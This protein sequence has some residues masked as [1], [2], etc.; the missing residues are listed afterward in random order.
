MGLR[1][2][3][4]SLMPAEGW[5]VPSN[6]PVHRRAVAAALKLLYGNA[7]AM[8]AGAHDGTDINSV[9]A[10][11]A[12][13]GGGRVYIDKGTVVTDVTIVPASS[14][15][16]EVN[17]EATIRWNG[18]AGG[19]VVETPATST[20]V[21]SGFYGR[22]VIDLNFL[23]ET[24]LN[25]HS[26]FRGHWGGFRYTNGSTTCALTRITGDSAAGAAEF[27]NLANVAFNLFDQM[28]CESSCG[29]GYVFDGRNDPVL[30]GYITENTFGPI[31]LANCKLKGLRFVKW[32]DNNV[33]WGQIRVSINADDAIGMVFQDDADPALDVGVYA[34]VFQYAAIDSFN[35]PTLQSCRKDDG[36]AFTNYTTAAKDDTR[37]DVLPLRAAPA[38]GDAIYVGCSSKFRC[39]GVLTSIAGV[40]GWTVTWEYWNGAAYVP[41]PGLTDETVGFTVFGIK[42]VYWAAAPADWQPDVING[43]GPY[44]HVRGR[45][46]AYPGPMTTQPKVTWIRPSNYKNRRAIVFNKSY[47]QTFQAFFQDPEAEGGVLVNNYR[48]ENSYYVVRMGS[49][50]SPTRPR[51][52][53]VYGAHALHEPDFDMAGAGGEGPSVYFGDERH[54]AGLGGTGINH[55]PYYRFDSGDYLWYD[56]TYNGFN[57]AVANLSVFGIGTGYVSAAGGVLRNA[58]RLLAK[59]TVAGVAPGAVHGNYGAKTDISTAAS[60]Y[61]LMAPLYVS[62]TA[63]GVFGAETLTVRLTVTYDDSSTTV[64]TKDFVAAGVETA[65]SDLELFNLLSDGKAIQKLSVDCQSTID[66]SAATGGCKF[67]GWNT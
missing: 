3:L 25:L 32:T 27:G 63:G 37:D 29:Y 65:L 64:I 41:I 8:L 49:V 1:N 53:R 20:L 30:S 19:S 42:M 18:A 11:V 47:Q 50:Y 26:T 33:F 62:L 46:S 52:V 67:L 38:V 14:V 16:V 22:G 66:G 9:I 54:H 2:A 59:R 10:A 45:L 55:Q 24:G 51:W 48:S 57:F 28:V 36:G 12:A 31:E 21:H 44:Y 7:V 34:N 6:A 58:K 15:V 39:L 5:V 43:A 17:E 61:G 60:H 4:A 40:G 56:R 23:A 35:M 13:S